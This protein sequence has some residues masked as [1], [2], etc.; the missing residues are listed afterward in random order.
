M[1][2]MYLTSILLLLLVAVFAT[3]VA[4]KPAA[5]LAGD[6]NLDLV[7]E[8]QKRQSAQIGKCYLTMLCPFS[9]KL[10]CNSLLTC[11]LFTNPVSIGFS[12]SGYNVT[13]GSAISISVVVSGLTTGNKVNVSVNTSDGSAKGMDMPLLLP[14]I[15]E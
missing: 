9:I 8:R 13:E 15:Y 12:P 2:Y 5:N 10:P 1:A 6:S 7:T 11:F 4:A 14:D 3:E